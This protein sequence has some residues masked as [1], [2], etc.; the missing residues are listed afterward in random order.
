[1]AQLKHLVKKL[2]KENCCSEML[3]T[4][5]FVG[6]LATM[7]PPYQLLPEVPSPEKVVTILSYESIFLDRC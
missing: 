4:Y 6:M 1:M 2:S 7:Q 3:E 5:R